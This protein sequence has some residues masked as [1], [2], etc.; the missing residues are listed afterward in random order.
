MEK[1]RVG[2]VKMPPSLWRRLALLST[3]FS[4]RLE[5][6]LCCVSTYS[7]RVFFREGG[8]VVLTDHIDETRER[9]GE[10][11]GEKERSSIERWNVERNAV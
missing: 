3:E 2:S 1:S 10:S 4:I 11:E 8:G 6:F 9:K 7:V 5:Q